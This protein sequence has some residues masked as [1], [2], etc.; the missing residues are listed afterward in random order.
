MDDSIKYIDICMNRC[1]LSTI[2]H[3]Y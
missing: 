3:T 2:I 1:V